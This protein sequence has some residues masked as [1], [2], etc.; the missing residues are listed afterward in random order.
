MTRLDLYK[1][2]S[3][4]PFEVN[5]TDRF[6]GYYFYTGVEYILILKYDKISKIIEMYRN[7]TVNEDNYVVFHKDCKTTNFL[8]SITESA[9]L[10]ELNKSLKTIKTIKNE[11]RKN[12]II[13]EFK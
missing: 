3:K 8:N 6:D 4:Y 1:I 12:R 10:D 2:M 5:Y 7:M 13:N 11:I 9:F